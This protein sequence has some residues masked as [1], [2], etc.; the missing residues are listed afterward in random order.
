MIEVEGVEVRLCVSPAEKEK[1]EKTASNTTSRKISR[2]VKADRTRSTQFRVHDPGGPSPPLSSDTDEGNDEKRSNKLPTTSDLA[3]S[4][5]QT[6]PPKEKAELQATI[7]QS[8]CL[9]QS[10]ISTASEGETSGIG[11]GEGFSLPGFLVDFLKGV[12]ERIQVRIKNVE[13]DVVLKLNVL[14]ETSNSS[15]ISDR[16]ESVTVRFLIQELQLDSVTNEYSTFKDIDFQADTG[17]EAK[18]MPSL[19]KNEGTRRISLQNI[20][21]MLLSDASVFAN[22]SRFVPPS[23]PEATQTGDFERSNRGKQAPSSQSTHSSSSS[24]MKYDGLSGQAMG[25]AVESSTVFGRSTA[26]INSERFANAIDTHGSE[27]VLAPHDP[28]QLESADVQDSVLADS[29]YSSSIQSQSDDNIIADPEIVLTDPAQSDDLALAFR[30]QNSTPFLEGLEDT[31][32]E[33]LTKSKIFSHE[34]AESMYMSAISHASAGSSA[35]SRR[36]PG[37]WGDSSS[38]EEELELNPDISPVAQVQNSDYALLNQDHRPAGQHEAYRLPDVLD[39]EPCVTPKQSA[40]PAASLSA[41]NKAHTVQPTAVL[42]PVYASSQ[43]SEHSTKSETPLIILKMFVFVDSMVMKL[44]H[45]PI[46]AISES[47]EII[48]STVKSHHHRAH[49]RPSSSSIPSSSSEEIEELSGQ[50]L[51]VEVGNVELV[52]DVGLTKLTILIMQQTVDMLGTLH[53]QRADAVIPE[54]LPKLIELKTRNICWKFV[55]SIKGF[56]VAGSQN[57]PAEIGILPLSSGAEVLLKAVVTD[58]CSVYRAS[59]PSMKFRVSM[60]KLSFGYDSSDIVSFDP[61][62]K[63]RESTRDT[64]APVDNDMVFMG[65]N[66]RGTLKIECTTLPVHV[67]L[68]LRRLDE[69]FGWFGGFSSMLGLGSS[70]MSTVTVVDKVRTAQPAKPRRGVHFENSKQ[71]K[72]Q[73]RQDY[74]EQKITARVGGIVLDLHGTSSSVRLE[75]SALK[76]VSRAEG[77]GLQLDKVNFSGPYLRVANEVPSITTKLANIRLEYLSTPKEDDLARLLSLLSPSKDK[78]EQDDDILIDTLIRQRRQGGVIRATIDRFD[79]RTSEL[80]DLEY[81]PVLAEELKK[82][83]TVTKYLPEDDRPGILTLGLV[84]NCQVEVFVNGSFGT[85]TCSAR[86]VKVAHVTLPNLT[87]FGITDVQIQRNK[88]QELVGKAFAADTGYEPQVPMI[89]GRFVGNEMDP[90]VKVKL[91]NFRIEYHVSVIMAVMGLSSTM[92]AEAIIF[93]IASS[94]AT[95]TNQRE[96]SISPAKPLSQTSSSSDRPI[97]TSKSLKFEIAIRDSIVGL[98][99]RNS[100]GR[101]LIVLTDTQFKSALLKEDE[102]TASLEIRKAYLM[103]IDDVLNVVTVDIPMRDSSSSGQHSQIQ[104]LSD[105]GYVSVGYISAAQATIKVVDIDGCQSIDVEVKDDLLVLESCADSTQTLLSIMNGMSP[106]KPP[107]SELKYR[108]EVV[109]VQDMLASLSGNAFAAGDNNDGSNEDYLLGLEDGDMVDDDVPENLEFVSSFYN[110]D[111]DGLYDGIA[112]SM[113]EDDLESIASP[114]GTQEIGERRSLASFEEKCQVA[115]GGAPLDFREDHFGV[116]SSIGGTAH[117]WDTKQN[118]YEL[119]NDFKIARS[120]LRIRVRDVHFIWNLFDGYDWEHTRDVISQAVADVQGKAF[121]RHLKAD[122]RKSLDAEEEEESVIGDFLFNSIYIGIPANRDPRDLSRQV[123]RNLDD[124]VSETESYATSSASGSPSRQ[125]HGSRLKGKRLRLSRSKLHKMTFE[126]KGVSADFIAF[127]TGL[128]ETQSSLD[129]RVHD[130]D[131]FD[132]VSTST[133]KKF[134]TYMHD[135]GE[136]ESGTSM[137]RLEILNVKPVPTLAASEIILKATV[138]PLRLHVDQ[139]ALDFMTRFFEFKDDSAPMPSSKSEPPFLQRVEVNSVR[140]MLDFKPKRV[141]YAGLRSGRTNEFMN[142]FILDRA[143]MVLRHVIIH[144]VSGFDRLGQMLNDIWMPDIKRN[145]L[146]GVLAGL[147]PVR[148][149]VN[150]GGGVRDLVVVPIREYRKDGRVVR[151]LQKG[152]LAFAKTTTTELAKLGAKLAIGTQTVLQGA[153]GFLTQPSQQTL[154]VSAGWEDSDLEEDEKKQISLYADQPVGVVQGLRG[155]YASLERDLLTA[156]DA[157]VAMPG[158]VMESGTAGGAARAVLR[159]APTIILRPAMGVTK[160]VGQTLMGAT[161]SL[162]PGNRRRIEDVSSRIS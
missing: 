140:L 5:L 117:R 65:S 95:V 161:N 49:F 110:P 127:P 37:E 97:T 101:G 63:L 86:E 96:F 128:E 29:S 81:F 120:P 139:D 55:D 156:R 41:L 79:C 78:Y 36:L 99:P 56:T 157:I 35:K 64:L 20:R 150:V 125:A 114:P 11:V 19:P 129:V 92:T 3:Q 14:S 44:R 38:S 2:G 85:A 45:K 116:S 24:N 28:L 30:W 93:D 8:Y 107:S 32:P 76:L 106:P 62:L 94:V 146:P 144:G 1:T 46:S 159:G 136:R 43:Q 9:E 33:D 91:H 123:N 34:E 152:A 80:R 90:T 61:S 73:E 126:L 137:I 131:I 135:A 84:R 160:A 39:K 155:A 71:V 47:A 42:N 119:T 70:M 40:T 108:T 27:G 6:E 115:P 50:D 105:M 17:A 153:E 133:W 109:P 12:V 51:L 89:M 142:F 58:M 121:E 74:S 100:P 143:D 7:A 154:D 148:S 102:V 134:A 53:S 72:P 16:S 68:D 112:E 59:G 88:S 149:L 13:L 23:S 54:P 87:A 132:H 69:T 60:R 67:S 124:L 82:L 26:S 111:P 145:Q 15:N 48:A 141:D 83:S 25:R 77:I 75:S 103:I 113:L 10:Q 98:N 118:T 162:D 151:S 122:G 31:S 158:E 147:A 22:L 66:V 130:L 21:G 104:G 52:G 18:D 4:F 57:S 138:L